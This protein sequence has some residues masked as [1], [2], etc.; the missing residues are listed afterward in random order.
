MSKSRVLPLSDV[1]ACAYA[2]LVREPL[3]AEAA[4]ESRPSSRP[5]PIR[6]GCACSARSPA[7]PAVKPASATSPADFDVTQPTISHHLKVL[8]DA[9]LLASER[10]ASWVYYSV[11]PEAL[12][13][14]VGGARAS[15]PTT[16]HRTERR[17]DRAP[18]T[19]D[20]HPAVVEKLSLLDRFLPVWIGIAMAAGLLLG[21]LIPGL[22]HRAESAFR[23][24]ASRCPS[25]SAC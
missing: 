11:V 15:P 12:S 6:C 4:A 17:H 18:S 8:K 24:T 23:S 1:S 16:L 9:G 14:P 7:T 13:E 5:S 2:P 21:R 20:A 22:E 25:R 10:R 3:S 19:T